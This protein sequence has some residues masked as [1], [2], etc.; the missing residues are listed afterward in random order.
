MG[1]SKLPGVGKR[2]SRGARRFAQ[3]AAAMDQE[4]FFVV[5]S[6]GKGLMI[7]TDCDKVRESLAC[8]ALRRASGRRS[9]LSNPTGVT[10]YKGESGEI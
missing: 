1:K 5:L 7:R 4:E 2:Q 9:V 6:K 8:Q 3:E 10:P